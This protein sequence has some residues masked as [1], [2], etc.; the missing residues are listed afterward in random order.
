[1]DDK[2][3]SRAIPRYALNEV[4]FSEK[5]PSRPSVH[6]V[7][8]D[9]EEKEKYRSSGVL[10]CTGSGST[11]WMK[12]ATSLTEEQVASVLAEL[13]QFP[14]TTEVTN[15]SIHFLSVCII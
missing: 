1:M 9:D 5:D 7:S 2:G 13:N 8:V 11:A 15:S 14:S 12:N 4:F 3:T 10:I 6:C